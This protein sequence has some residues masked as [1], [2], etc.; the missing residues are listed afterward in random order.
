M[1]QIFLASLR[2]DSSIRAGE[3]LIWTTGSLYEGG[4]KFKAEESDATAQ[5]KD[6]LM[7]A[8]HKKTNKQKRSSRWKAKVAIKGLT[9]APR[10]HLSACWLAEL[11][12]GPPFPQPMNAVQQAPSRQ[13]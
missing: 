3:V 13:C 5:V 4:D 9:L 12:H 10:F 7:D 8:Y 2:A 6:A 11:Y 1:L